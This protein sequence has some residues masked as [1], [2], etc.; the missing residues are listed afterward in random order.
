MKRRIVGIAVLSMATC[1]LSI[2]RQEPIEELMAKAEAA[3]GADK[4]DLCMKVADREL[5]LT[6]TAYKANKPNEGNTALD[7]V[8]KYSDM[9]HTAAI[10]SGKKLKGT[11]I[12]IRKIAEHLHDLKFNADAYDQPVIQTAID[13]LQE[14]RTELL[15]TMFGSKKK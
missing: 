11:E 5:K 9:A 3:T 2:A 15:K 7:Q 1:L 6:L 12:K 13:K 4:A 10:E 8:V 14:F